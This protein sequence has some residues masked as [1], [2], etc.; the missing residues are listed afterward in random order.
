MQGKSRS[1]SMAYNKNFA[2]QR[3][4]S[5]RFR[6][7]SAIFSQ[8]SGR[9]LYGGQLGARMRQVPFLQSRTDRRAVGNGHQGV[10]KI[11]QPCPFRGYISLR[12]NV[13]QF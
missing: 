13:F 5:K 7:Q 10:T 11:V 8:R 9:A 3:P 2:Q 6:R 12:L 1:S 4:T